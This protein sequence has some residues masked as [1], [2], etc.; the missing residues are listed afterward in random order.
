MLK[1]KFLLVISG[2]LP[3]EQPAE[4][5]GEM[6]K[7]SDPVHT[8]LGASL[9]WASKQKSCLFKIF[10]VLGLCDDLWVARMAVG[11]AS[12]RRYWKLPLHLVEAMPVGSKMGPTQAKDEPISDSGNALGV[13]FLRERKELQQRNNCSQ[14]ND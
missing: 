14:R 12:V 2:C 5:R 4:P 1:H 7:Q 13:M 6:R 9:C 11:V 3:E 10:C 8:A